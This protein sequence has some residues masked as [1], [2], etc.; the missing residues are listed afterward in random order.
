MRAVKASMG[1]VDMQANSFNYPLC[2]PERN[3]VISNTPAY[4]TYQISPGGRDHKVC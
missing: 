4:I 2:H 3:G 1:E